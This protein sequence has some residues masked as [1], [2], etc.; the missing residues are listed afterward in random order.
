MA[1]SGDSVIGG[2]I[3]GLSYA[4]EP[5]H[6]NNK[7]LG[8]HKRIGHERG[9]VKRKKRPP[10]CSIYRDHAGNNVEFSTGTKRKLK[11]QIGWHQNM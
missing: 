5:L 8:N 10:D 6:R 11:N 4:L 9:E 1:A 3:T 2:Q 7:W